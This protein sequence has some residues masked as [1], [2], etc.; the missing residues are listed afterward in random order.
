MRSFIYGMVTTVLLLA[1]VDAPADVFKCSDA[2]GGI[3]Y[4][5]TPCPESEPE[6]EELK[7]E[8]PQEASETENAADP[9]R[10]PPAVIAAKSPEVVAQCKKKYRD[11]IDEIDAEMRHGYTSEQ[12]EVYKQRL[13]VFTEQ[14]RAC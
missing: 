12:G 3:I 1:C 13:L 2:D 7:N 11:A 5:Q 8:S 4:Q 10:S 9:D 14:L 6:K